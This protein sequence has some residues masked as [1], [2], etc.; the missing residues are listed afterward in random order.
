VGVEVARCLLDRLPGGD[1]E[2]PLREGVRQWTALAHAGSPVSAGIRRAVAYLRLHYA[3]PDL[4]QE[5]VARESGLGRSRFCQAFRAEMGMTYVEH[6][7]FLRVEEARRLLVETSRPLQEIAG[8]V[9]YEAV[10]SL[11]RAFQEEVGVAPGQY[12]KQRAGLT[13]TSARG[14]IKEKE[15][16]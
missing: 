14:T 13:E 8:A 1:V 15:P 16:T 4:T 2:E 9:G 10:S 6:L 11:E 5:A 7:T 3:S 12:R